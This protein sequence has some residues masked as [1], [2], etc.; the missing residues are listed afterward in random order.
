[1]HIS[2]HPAFLRKTN[3]KNLPQEALSE[4]EASTCFLSHVASES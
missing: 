4:V 1:M 3:D 2:T